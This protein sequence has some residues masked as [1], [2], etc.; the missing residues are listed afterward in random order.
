MGV[1]LD[2]APPVPEAEVESFLGRDAVLGGRALVVAEGEGPGRRLR[3]LEF[4]L[5]RVDRLAKAAES[6]VPEVGLGSD[7]GELRHDG[8]GGGLAALLLLT[9]HLRASR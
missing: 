3:T 7:G 6:V 4:A 5:G 2:E 9:L 1:R 8:V